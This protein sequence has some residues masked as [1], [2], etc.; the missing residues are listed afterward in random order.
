M[1]RIRRPR[2]FNKCDGL[3]PRAGMNGMHAC[4]RLG[5]TDPWEH[6]GYAQCEAGL[7]HFL[8]QAALRQSQPRLERTLCAAKICMPRGL[9]TQAGG[10]WMERLL[11]V[12]RDDGFTAA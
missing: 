8:V 1:W 10:S 12:G 5:R 6:L 9:E 11:I 3:G 4:N 7:S 2:H